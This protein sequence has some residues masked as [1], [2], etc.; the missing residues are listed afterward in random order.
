MDKTDNL[1]F[2][3]EYLAKG[4]KYIAGVDEVGRGPLCG[5]VVTCA[6]IMPLDSQNV[7]EGIT[8][9]KK[10][11]EKKREMLYDKILEKAIAVKISQADNNVIDEIN[12]LNATKKC[13]AESVKG[14]SV[15][16]DIVFVDALKLD[17]ISEQLSIIKGD[18]KSYSIGAASIVAKV[19]RD[20]MM[21][22]Y[23]KQFPGYG[24]SKNK[25]Y[26]TKEHIEALKEMG[27][28]SIHRRTFIKN[29]SVNEENG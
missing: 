13:M 16:P 28:C 4:Y 17:I 10:L 21:V 26:G 12:I 7:I 3:K 5:P 19:F 24:L 14:L 25:G 27:P 29:F 8:D 2:E 20:R 15:V 1:I 23:D 18:L 22:E 11:S 6:V 9:S